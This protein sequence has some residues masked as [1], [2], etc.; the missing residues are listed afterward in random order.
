[1]AGALFLKQDQDRARKQHL[2]PIHFAYD[3]ALLRRKD[4]AIAALEEDYR[5]HDPWLVFLQREP[6]FDFIHADERYRDLVR[7][8]GLPPAY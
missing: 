1:V 7:K 5:E 8:M 2:S 3:Y 6:A 4:E